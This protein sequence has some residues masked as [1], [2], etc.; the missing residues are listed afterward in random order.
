MNLLGQSCDAAAIG[1]PEVPATTTLR[2]LLQPGLV[3]SGDEHL[4]LGVL[5]VTGDFSPFIV[6][7]HRG[8]IRRTEADR[9]YH[10]S[11]PR[12][13]A[14]GGDG[15]TLVVLAVGHDDDDFLVFPLGAEPGHSGL[16]RFGDHRSLAGDGVRAGVVQ[17]GPGG[18]VVGGQRELYKAGPGEQ[19]DTD[20]VSLQPRNE[21]G[22]FQLGAVEAGGLQ[23][24]GQHA[25]GDVQ[26]Y[27]DLDPALLD[28]LNVAPPLGPGQRQDQ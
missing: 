21:V 28:D 7:G 27:H 20:L 22:D 6:R 10:R 4:T 16:D 13:I 26:G 8:A 5:T 9:V 3:D 25:P 12:R 1:C 11:L 17:V 19:H 14:G 15:I 2:D 23:V 18:G 24:L